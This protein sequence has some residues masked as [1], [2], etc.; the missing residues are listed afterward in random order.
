MSGLLEGLVTLP[1]GGLGLLYG[2]KG[3]GK[4]SIAFQAFERPWLCSNEMSVQRVKAY[5][6]RLRV[7][8]Q[9]IS[10]PVVTLDE[11]GLPVVNFD[12]PDPVP[13][14]LV[15]DSITYSSHPFEVLV[16]LQQLC[17][18]HGARALA[19]A[20]VT[21]EGEARGGPK[22]VHLP[23]VVIRLGA[24]EGVHQLVVE[25]NR[26]GP[27]GERSYVLGREGASLPPRGSYYTIE[28]HAPRFK[29][30]QHPN[31]GARYAAL[32]RAIE[33]LHARDQPVPPMLALPPPPLAT[34]ALESSLYPLGFAEPDDAR[35]REAFARANGI[36]Y[37]YP[38]RAA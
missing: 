19:I 26:F 33:R 34:A 13:R 30:V 4:T 18:L 25:K 14:H 27:E 20:Q 35:S 2:P 32:Y 3:F 24:H 7:P 38:R 21:A 9:G 1:P 29:L 6:R 22:I 36:P 15:L 23:D 12:L 5:C 11:E 31:P 17:E 10:Q 8:H 37:F 16:A 28:G